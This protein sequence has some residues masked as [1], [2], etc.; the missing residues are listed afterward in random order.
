[1]KI[2]IGSAEPIQGFTMQRRDFIA[3]LGAVAWPLAAQAQQRDRIRRISVS[4]PSGNTGQ[5]YLRLFRRGLAKLGWSEGSNL[6]M[7]IPQTDIPRSADTIDEM[8]IIAKEMVALAPEV[9]VAGS[10]LLIGALQRETRT[11][12]IIFVQ[13]GDPIGAGFVASVPRP[14]GNITTAIKRPPLKRGGVAAIQAKALTALLCSFSS[15]GLQPHQA[16][17][18]HSRV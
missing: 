7:D 11:I 12:P 18:E 14:G 16:I 4:V 9:I 8:R 2:A 10:T 3:G 13:V 1:M 6:Q 5:D 15:Q 17:A